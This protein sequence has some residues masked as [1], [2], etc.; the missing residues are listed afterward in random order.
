M[1]IP[2]GQILDC[3]HPKD[4]EVG[5]VLLGKGGVICS[6]CNDQRKRDAYKPVVLRRERVNIAEK[7]GFSTNVGTVL[8]PEDVERKKR[9][10]S[11]YPLSHGNCCDILNM[12]SE[13][14]DH[15]IQTMPDVAADCEV[16]IVRLTEGG[17]ERV[18]VVDERIPKGYRRHVCN[19][20]GVYEPGEDQL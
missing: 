9:T 3:G 12:C 14:A 20:C 19:G 1:P 16:E 5:Y 6:P 17:R 15:I 8:W 4:G 11:P 10:G 13:N 18:R 2:D 7:M